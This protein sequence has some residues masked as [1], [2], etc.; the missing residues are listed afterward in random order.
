MNQ[1][2]SESSP[3]LLQHANNPV[4]WQAWNPN[5]LA[6]AKENNKL[7]IV[8]IGYSACHWCHVME[9][10]S[11]EDDEVAQTMNNNFVSIK[12]DREERPDVD[13]VYMKAVQIMTGRG[14]WPLNIVALPDGRPVWGGT[15]FRKDEWI[16][17]LEQLQL[18]YLNDPEKMLDYAEKLHQGI[19]S[20]SPITSPV[21]ETKLN[22]E[23]LEPLIEK[24]M[25]SC[26]WEFGGMARAPK[27]MMPNNY[28]FLLRYGHQKQNQQVL[29]FVHLTLTKMAYGGLFDTVGGG[30]SRYSVDMKW[31]VPHF[32]KMMYDNGQLVSLYADA[33][34][35]TKNPLYKEVIEK[36]LTFISREL[37]N[38][39][40]GFYCALDADSLN[41]EHHPEE[42]AFYVWKKDELQKLLKEDFKLFSLVFNIND[43]GY[44]EENN[45]VLIQNQ[46]LEVIAK[47]NQMEV[48]ELQ[49]KKMFWEQL[50]FAERE[51]R[52][53]PRLDDK[54]LTSWNAIMLKG[55]VDTY[56]ALADENYLQTALQNAN[57][58]IKNLWAPEGNLW[59]NYKNGKSNINGY[60]EDYC[61]VIDAFISLYEV[62]FDEMWLQ[63]A[64][65]LTDYCFDHFY[66][67]KS[68]FFA[69][70]SNKDEVIIT[71]HFET[72]DNVIPASNSVMSN[73]LFKLSIYFDNQYYETVCRRMLENV[74]P[75]IDYPSAYSNWLNVFLNY[76][77]DQ[78][79]L[80]ICGESASEYGKEINAQYIPNLTIAGSQK[81]SALP[82]LQNRFSETE[83]LFYVCQ[84]KT[85]GK[86]TAKFEE[87]MSL[88]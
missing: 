19:E 62:T 63:H 65:Q 6:E 85:C 72:E 80:A 21:S 41:E 15:Y 59:H 44:W 66:D 16:N 18:L 39:T 51:K 38:T 1:L 45:F 40:N 3:Y 14:G 70:T 71:R 28:Q 53:K 10:E 79:E 24:W 34:K 55:Y 20:L 5:S 60:L 64:K 58:I 27:F 43:F 11:F 35:L 73:N 76:S 54:S 17:T 50:L 33:Y 22:Q 49:S 9:H 23:L 78:K 56:K 87:V 2:Q 82:F 61:F 52:S 83:T 48:S 77:E 75:N 12:V 37:T 68:R 25:R 42:G 69:F 88:I 47:N 36:T 46:P 26:D 32:E 29:D 81:P 31:H 84:N 7:I 4:H 8:S 13:A 30:F 74:V 67:E 57:F 86:P